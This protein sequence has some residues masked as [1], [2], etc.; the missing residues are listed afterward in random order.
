MPRIFL[1]MSGFLAV[2]LLQMLSGNVVIAEQTLRP[3]LDNPQE[4]AHPDDEVASFELT[5][6]LLDGEQNPQRR[7][8]LRRTLG[9]MT[10]PKVG[11]AQKEVL[12][13]LRN[14]G[15]PRYL[16]QNRA[17]WLERLANTRQRVGN[18]TRETWNRGINLFR[19]DAP[20]STR[21]RLKKGGTWFTRMF[22]SDQI[23]SQEPLTINE[24][25]SQ[26]RI[27]P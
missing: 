26:D 12:P 13:K 19:S 21:S 8:F 5:G 20:V 6:N 15:Q 7:G 27:K 4:V 23:E 11:W 16:G 2:V 1:L 17:T 9:W 10:W 25:M 18:Q 3:S 22:Q 14:S 24:W